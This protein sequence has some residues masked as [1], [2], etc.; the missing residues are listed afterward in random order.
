MAQ[1]GNA[2]RA[3]MVSIAEE[4]WDFEAVVQEEAIVS[5][6]SPVNPDDAADVVRN[7]MKQHSASDPAELSQMVEAVEAMVNLPRSSEEKRMLTCDKGTLYLWVITKWRLEAAS[8]S[9]ERYR[10]LACEGEEADDKTC[11]ALDV[12][13]EKC[14]ERASA[15][16]L[17][18]ERASIFDANMVDKDVEQWHEADQQELVVDHDFDGVEAQE[19]FP[20]ADKER[21]AEAAPPRPSYYQPCGNGKRVHVV[22][23]D[24][25][26][27]KCL[28]R[29]R[30]SPRA[31]CPNEMTTFCYHEDLSARCC[32]SSAG[33]KASEVKMRLKTKKFGT[34]QC[35]SDMAPLIGQ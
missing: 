29:P 25:S 28:P 11:T 2:A 19:E 8:S 18:E 16:E 27:N 23:R 30:D 13:A 14:P 35:A 4:P 6:D 10:L 17:R 9:K 3:R 15:E 21:D 1:H 32:C 20:D 34:A 24:V 5:G 26:E 31:A 33:I 22:K 7:L 12:I